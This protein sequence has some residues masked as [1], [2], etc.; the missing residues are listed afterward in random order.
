MYISLGTNTT[1][2]TATK[3]LFTGSGR[4]EFWKFEVSYSFPSKTSTSALKFRINEPP[5]DGFCYVLPNNGSTLTLFRIKCTNWYDFHEILDYTFYGK[6]IDGSYSHPP[7]SSSLGWTQT[8]PTPILLAT[9]VGTDTELRLPAG[10]PRTSI[11]ILSVHVRDTLNGVTEE[12]VANVTVYRN[13]SEVVQLVEL[14]QNGTINTVNQTTEVFQQLVHPDLNLQGQLFTSFSQLI[15]EIG[16]DCVH[17][18]V[19]GR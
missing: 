18:A 14:V 7:I 9:T 13:T 3:D 4:N 8:D 19:K 11:L 1:N 6:I 16:N 10:D 2:F 17:Q 15:K 12:H 5:S